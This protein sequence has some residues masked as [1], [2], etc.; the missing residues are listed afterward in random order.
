MAASYHSCQAVRS[1]QELISPSHI[2]LREQSADDA[3]AHL[4]AGKRTGQHH[5]DTCLTSPSA[6]FGE[7]AAA[8]P[9]PMVVSHEQDSHMKFI[10]KHFA[11][12]L[13][14]IHTGHLRREMQHVHLIHLCLPQQFHLLV[15][16]GKQ[17]GH[18]IGMQHLA[19]MPVKRNKHRAQ[20]QRTGFPAQLPYQVLMSSMHSIEKAYGGNVSPHLSTS[21]F[22]FLRS[23]LPLLNMHSMPFQTSFSQIR[24][25]FQPNSRQLSAAS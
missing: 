25:V 12:K 23:K 14:R 16:G 9:K 11:H 24:L 6:V 20:S 21:I 17:A 8:A 18:I 15:K 13:P 7:G 19:R 2:A 5:L 3:A 1:A 10:G 4:F 22:S